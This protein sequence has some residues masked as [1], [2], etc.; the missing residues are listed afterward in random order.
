MGKRTGFRALG[1]DKTEVNKLYSFILDRVKEL[2][3]NMQVIIVDHANLNNDDFQSV[4]IEKW[5]N[6]EKLIPESWKI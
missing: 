4:V 3:G 1:N 2:N 5:W 6:G